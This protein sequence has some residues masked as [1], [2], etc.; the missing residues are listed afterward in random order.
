LVHASVEQLPAVVTRLADDRWRLELGPRQL[1]QHVEVLYTRGADT[2]LEAV[3][4]P[5]LVNRKVR[6]T[7]WTLYAPRLL[8]SPEPRQQGRSG[9]AEQHL[10][11][12]ASL[13]DL[14]DLKAEVVGEHLPEEIARWYDAWR[15]RYRAA[16]AGLRRELIA[17]RRDTAQ[18][19]ENVQA[20][21]LDE[22]IR[23][24]D[25][26]LGAARS[27]ARQV[28]QQDALS[29][30]SAVARGTML[31]SHFAASDFPRLQVRFASGAADHFVGRILVAIVTLI[32][33]GTATWWLRTRTVPTLAPWIVAGGIGLAWWL[34]LG[35]S[36]LG[37][38][39]FAAA[40]SV[41]LWSRWPT[42][43]PQAI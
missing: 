16:R 13:A 20:R 23:A 11:R 14:V 4:A 32:L 35:P 19:A 38:V 26:R 2:G 6:D 5:R 1:P 17:G 18:A 22:H 29:Q 10:K 12:L 9:P 41:A 3:Q 24:V 15:A 31:P 27:A 25:E 30:L 8:G 21:K 28:P 34:L 36:F 40:A 37:F 33:S 39:A 7:L 43:R 42:P